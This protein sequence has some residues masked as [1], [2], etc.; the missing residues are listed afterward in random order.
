MGDREG[1]RRQLTARFVGHFIGQDMRSCPQEW[2][3]EVTQLDTVSDWFK[4]RRSGHHMPS[5][6]GVSVELRPHKQRETVPIGLVELSPYRVN[7]T[8]VGWR[9][10][11][12]MNPRQR[13]QLIGVLTS[14]VSSTWTSP[15]FMLS[16][17]PTAHVGCV[18]ATDLSCL[19]IPQPEFDW[20]SRLQRAPARNLRHRYG[21]CSGCPAFKYP[22][23]RERGT[24]HGFGE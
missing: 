7:L 22:M 1:A 8:F 2:R 16:T 12:H 24:K 4:G 10:T 11:A 14:S 6:S 19:P 23:V 21:H 18:L 13:I 9:R 15:R 5:Y 17:M 20:W 3:T